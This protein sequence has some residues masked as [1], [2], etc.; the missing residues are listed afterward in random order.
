MGLNN[1]QHDLGLYPRA[2]VVGCSLLR[3][4]GEVNAG[5]KHRSQRAGISVLVLPATSPLSQAWCHQWLAKP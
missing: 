2:K 5:D 3:G 4:K 1:H